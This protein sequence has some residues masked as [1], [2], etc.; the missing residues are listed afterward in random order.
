MASMKSQHCDEECGA[1]INAI[2]PG[3]SED[4]DDEDDEEI[5]Y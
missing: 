2:L 5:S 4:A 3:D 1:F